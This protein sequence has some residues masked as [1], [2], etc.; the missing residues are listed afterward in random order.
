[1]IVLAVD[2]EEDALAL[3]TGAIKLNMPDASLHPFGSPA[4]ALEFARR[5]QPDIAFLD[6]SMPGMT[7]LEL[8]RKLKEINPKVNIIFATA[9]SEY[10]G[11][12]FAIHAS[13]YLMK[14]ITSKAVKRELDNLR[15]PV[16]TTRMPVF[17]R[18]FGNFEIFINGE[19][20]SF[21]RK[22][23][24]E[25]LAYLVNREGASVSKKELCLALFDDPE[26]T[27]RSMDY[28]AKI[29]KDMGKTL[30]AAGAGNIV[31]IDR[32][33]CYVH[34]ENYVCDAAEYLKGNPEYINRF[35]GEYMTQFEWAQGS[36]SKFYQ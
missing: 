27:H 22:P 14:P 28:L 1:M 20:V 19:P 25:V 13:G 23:A 35:K 29:I 11:E 5:N 26:Y 21:S 9:Y 8:A 6:I 3:I 24:K 34:P 17:I 10:M 15:A 12:A 30:E 16:D 4:D 2:D 31:S 32:K 36:A 33:E 18:T 7:G